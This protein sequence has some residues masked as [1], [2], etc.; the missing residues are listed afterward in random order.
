MPQNF[1]E[2]GACLTVIWDRSC[3]GGKELSAEATVQDR[4]GEDQGCKNKSAMYYR[5]SQIES[6]V[7]MMVAWKI[8][9][10]HY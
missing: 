10:K 8:W 2:N 7:G 4:D 6:I 3:S 9:E 1:P 5:V